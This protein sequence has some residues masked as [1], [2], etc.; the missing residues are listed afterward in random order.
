MRLLLV[1]SSLGPGGAERNAS[2]MANFWAAR[3]HAVSIVTLAVGDDFYTL[4]R[5]VVRYKL[6]ALTGSTGLLDALRRNVSRIGQLRETFRQ[7]APDV[8]ISFLDQTN[9]LVLLAARGLN[10]PVIV[11]ERSD[12]AVR[13]LGRVW[14]MLRRATYARAECVVVQ[15][16]RAA[17]YFRSS[18][19]LRTVVIPN[20][21]EPPSFNSFVGLAV[22]RP[23]V[24]GVGRFGPEKGFDLLIR[25]FAHVASDYPQ[26]SLVLIG[27]G[28]MRGE[29]ERLALEQGIASRVRFLGNQREV[30]TL[31]AQTDLY[32]L[33]SRFEGFPNALCEAMA[34][35]RAVVSFDCPSGP[36]EIIQHGDDGLLVPPEDVA[37]LAETIKRLMGDA[38]LR[39]RL[40]RRARDIVLRF[41]IDDVMA[42]WE[43]LFFEAWRKRRDA[44]V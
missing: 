17:A 38:S 39:S 1:I 7:L 30:I 23:N 2:R 12:P 15:T 24:M 11:S 33:S 8:L 27:E 42:R 37:A 26:W 41:G 36:G 43:E 34:I 31:L 6:D 4:D 5:R 21:V 9:I 32:V 16:A 18:K 22:P 10:V 40:G 25:A 3:G 19:K 29:L 44:G 13:P 14:Q 35:G 28:P 20:S